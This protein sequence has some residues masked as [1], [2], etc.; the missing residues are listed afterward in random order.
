MAKRRI[1]VNHSLP[2]VPRMNGQ[3]ERTIRTLKTYMKAAAREKRMSPEDYIK[4]AMIVKNSAKSRFEFSPHEHLMR[5]PLRL[6]SKL[7]RDHPDTPSYLEESPEAVLD[8]MERLRQKYV[9][10]YVK[11]H[12]R[13]IVRHR[14]SPGDIV[15]RIRPSPN[16]FGEMEV[17][18]PYSVIKHKGK[19]CWQVVDRSL[20]PRS[21]VCSVLSGS[22]L[23]PYDYGAAKR[24]G[25]REQ[26]LPKI[27]NAWSEPK[28][29]RENDMFL[30]WND[31]R[32]FLTI[33]SCFQNDPEIS[34]VSA[35]EYVINLQGEP[36]ALRQ[37]NRHAAI[38]QGTRATT[39]VK[40]SAIALTHLLLSGDS[41]SFLAGMSLLLGG[42]GVL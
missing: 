42:G 8:R 2:K 6:P 38:C 18:G 5:G 26:L 11:R 3:A 19:S 27:L 41:T 40:Y 37:S 28:E 12:N 32:T 7:E 9:R 36:E 13:S 20:A 31:A 21:L 34:R 35:T 10:Q 22:E 23:E 17:T 39:N 16:V 29:L 33:Y 4:E 15:L 25:M 30:A 24:M 14:F 1:T